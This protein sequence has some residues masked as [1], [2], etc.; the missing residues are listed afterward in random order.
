MCVS[1]GIDG[2]MLG[3]F[4]C[5]S[6]IESSG[7]RRW[8]GLTMLPPACTDSCVCHVSDLRTGVAKVAATQ[9]ADTWP[10]VETCW[11]FIIQSQVVRALSDF[12]WSIVTPITFPQRND[13]PCRKRRSC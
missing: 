11:N 6:W 10:D 9:L 13:S 1:T 5:I 8:I 3:I 12:N 4:L 7:C 2:L